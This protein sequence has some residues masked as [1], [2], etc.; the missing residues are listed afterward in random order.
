[1]P[2]HL[3]I[4]ILIF[5]QK[6]VLL[7]SL[8]KFPARLAFYIYCRHISINKKEMLAL[9]GPLLIAANHPN[10]FFDAIILTTLFKKPVYSLARGDAFKKPFIARLLA[11]LNILPVYRVTEGVENLEHNYTTFDRCREIFKQNGIV[12]IFC[13]GRCI[14]EW[15]LRPLMKGT[16]RLAISSWQDGIPLKV[17]PT[18]I[19]YNSFVTFGKNIQL[20]FGNCITSADID[21]DNGHGKSI[22]SFNKQLNEQLQQ[23][24]IEINKADRSRIK[25]SFHITVSWVKKILLC[26]PAIAGWLLHAPLYLPLKRFA[27]KKAAPF[28]HYDS[29]ITGMLFLIYPIY[30]MLLAAIAYLITKN[31]L[32]WL[33][34]L[35]LPGCAWAYTQVKHQFED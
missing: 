29:V 27:L 21:T 3:N 18:G 33:L 31:P 6:L 7:F 2:A 19:N 17:I 30:L 11:S 24:V 16:A 23:L 1:L 15:H 34:M 22:A 14:N 8:L 9:H 12:L 26:I 25:S 20:G 4:F 28:D 35:A 5:R 32:S 10:S 13:E